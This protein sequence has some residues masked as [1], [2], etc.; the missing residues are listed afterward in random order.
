MPRDASAHMTLDVSINPH[1]KGRRGRLPKC[2]LSTLRTDVEKVGINLRNAK[3]L[4]ELCR[5]AA[6]RD[7]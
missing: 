3:E 7:Q 5:L 4:E 1:L 2:F 6:D